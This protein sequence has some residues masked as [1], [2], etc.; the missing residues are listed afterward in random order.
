MDIAACAVPR[1]ECLLRDDS[2]TPG[3][4][5]TDAAWI[6]LTALAGWKALVIQE[7]PVLRRQAPSKLLGD[8]F[9]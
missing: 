7:R 5:W 4:D 2:H 8:G 3:R 1:S 6:G 9:G